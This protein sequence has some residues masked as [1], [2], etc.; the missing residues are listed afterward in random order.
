MEN[1]LYQIGI[2]LCIN[3]IYLYYY[4]ILTSTRVLISWDIFLLHSLRQVLVD[5]YPLA[6]RLI[7][8][9]NGRDEIQCNDTGVLFQ[10]AIYQ[11][12]LEDTREE[13][14]LPHQLDYHRMLPI[15]FYR[16][17]QDPLLA[18]QLN[19]F[20]DGGV[21][22][23]VMMLHKIAD[24]YSI[25]LFLDSWA[26]LARGLTYGKSSFN[27]SIITIPDKTIIT[28]EAIDYYREQHKSI[29]YQQYRLK[30]D[31][32]NNN[33]HHRILTKTSPNGPSPLKS[34]VLEFYSDG[35][36]ECK[37]D[38]H[39]REMIKN[40]QQI[41]TKD[42]LFGLLL[43]AIIRSKKELTEEDAVKLI[44]GVNGRTVMQKT[45]D[46]DFYFGNWMITRSVSMNKK[47]IKS[48]SLVEAAR[49]FQ[50][51]SMNISPSLFHSL[52]K[53]YTLNE[54]MTVH[55][56]SYQPNSDT[57][58]TGNDISMLPFWRIDFGYGRPDRTRGYITSGGNGCLVI[59]GRSDG[60]KGAMYDVQ[61]QMDPDSIKAFVND[62]EIKKYTRRIL[63]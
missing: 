50:Q 20:L 8:I 16:S 25:C 22:L 31:S 11:E 3:H 23:G 54:D 58:I 30:T 52:S 42:A 53:I 4:S 7:D 56:L 36:L 44:F 9:G 35:L 12:K 46:I 1:Y 63:Y 57:Q 26:K 19:R 15:H 17:Y 27:R 6:G 45:K 47:Q 5:F 60:N 41:S 51:Q 37:K 34:I 13:G 49:A 59:F 55:Y 28:D 40:R 10:E 14:Y 32:S 62:H 2:S 48:T 39:T 29:S 43:R 33:N 38:A 21:V 18:I 61:L 24:T